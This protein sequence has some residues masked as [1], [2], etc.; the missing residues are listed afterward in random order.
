MSAVTKPGT[1]SGG[2]GTRRRLYSGRSVAGELLSDGPSEIA[3]VHTLSLSIPVSLVRVALLTRS[4]AAAD[5]DIIAGLVGKRRTGCARQRTRGRQ[6]LLPCYR[7]LCGGDLG[8]RTLSS[9][10]GQT[11]CYSAVRAGGW[12]GGAPV[13]PATL[14]TKPSAL[15]WRAMSD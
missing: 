6:P 13:T 7:H 15:P 2:S 9:N 1:C 8:A 10:S 12:G 4:R 3:H 11:V 5:P 14:V